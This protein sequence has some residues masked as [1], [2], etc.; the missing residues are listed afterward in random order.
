MA[1]LELLLMRRLRMQRKILAQCLLVALYMVWGCFISVSAQSVPRVAVNARLDRDGT[2]EVLER[3]LVTLGPDG[4]YGVVRIIPTEFNTDKERHFYQF[5][6]LETQLDN[7]L[8]RFVVENSNGS[9]IIQL[10][11]ENKFLTGRHLIALHYLLRKAVSYVGKPHLHWDAI[12]GN[13]PYRI[14][15]FNLS[16]NVPV[17]DARMVQYSAMAGPGGLGRPVMATADSNGLRIS[18]TN[19]APA[20]SLIVNVDLPSGVVTK[21]GYLKQ[22]SWFFADWWPTFALPVFVFILLAAVRAACGLAVALPASSEE[23]IQLPEGLTPAELGT[24]LDDRCDLT[25][26][27]ATL[28]DLAARGYLKIE[29]LN[30]DQFISLSNRDYLFTKLKDNETNL[31]EHEKLLLAAI[32]NVDSEG[33]DSTKLSEIRTKFHIYGEKIQ[34]AVYRSLIN[35]GQFL[36]APAEVPIAYFAV[37]FGLALIGLYLVL[38]TSGLSVAIGFGCLLSALVTFSFASSM[39]SRTFYGCKSLRQTRQFRGFLLTAGREQIQKTMLGDSAQFGRYLPYALVLGA[40]DK[41]AEAFQDLIKEAPNWYRPYNELSNSNFSAG[42]FVS[43][44]GSGMRTIERTFS[45]SAVSSMG[46][47]SAKS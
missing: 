47:Q 19:I 39:P 23:P 28:F 7:T 46:E 31:A 17:P 1:P 21:P 36:R 18:A 12:G 42:S 16:L 20:E 37:G 4:S 33:R 6:L 41:L 30:S 29:E 10:G 2:L 40:A 34:T 9:A 25:D 15:D 32:F 3:I 8:N 5:K 14:D 44:L 24:L 45:L 43:S 13:Y 26:I 11:D 27:I 38:S 22:F 35:K